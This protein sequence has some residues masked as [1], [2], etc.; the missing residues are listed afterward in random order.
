MKSIKLAL[1]AS[2]VMF[3]LSGCM[4][5]GLSTNTN[6]STQL[7]TVN[8]SAGIVS[9]LSAEQQLDVLVAQYYDESLTYSPIS[10]TY[11]GRKRV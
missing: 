6:T 5:T 4:N 11:N 10:A 9:E 7:N 3:A 8:A 1:V 2:G